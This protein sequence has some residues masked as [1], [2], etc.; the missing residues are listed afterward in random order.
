MISLKDHLKG[1]GPYLNRA[2]DFAKNFA[3][4]KQIIFHGYVNGITKKHLYQNSDIFIFPTDHGEGMPNSLV[5]AMAFG[6]PIITRPVGGIKDVFT[7]TKNGFMTESKEPKKIC[8]LIERIINDINLW[9]EISSFNYKLA[10][11][12]FYA[13]KVRKRLEN[14][15]ENTLF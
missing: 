7:N 1:D 8:E 13:S 2:K 3:C 9:E 5:E 6:L 10:K 12:R 11:E 4:N 14:I 15:Y